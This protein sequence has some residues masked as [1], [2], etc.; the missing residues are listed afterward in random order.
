MT[1]AID[2]RNLRPHHG[3]LDQAFEEQCFQI[4]RPTLPEHV[5]RERPGAPEAGAAAG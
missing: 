5:N 2:F 1:V 4:L 3:S